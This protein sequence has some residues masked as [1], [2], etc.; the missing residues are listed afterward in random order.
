MFMNLPA[1]IWDL[2]PLVS[3]PHSGGPLL[4]PT[5]EECGV[6]RRYQGK[7]AVT[8]AAGLPELTLGFR[9]AWDGHLKE[10]PHRDSS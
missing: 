9:T 1:P 3:V 8:R 2:G 10:H 5:R 6:C 7:I 4:Y